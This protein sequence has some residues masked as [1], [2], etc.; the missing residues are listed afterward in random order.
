MEKSAD[1]YAVVEDGACTY[2]LR[3]AHCASVSATSTH[4]LVFSAHDL[5]SPARLTNARI[6]L[7]R[8]RMKQC[9]HMPSSMASTRVAG[10]TPPIRVL[11]SELKIRIRA[12]RV[13]MPEMD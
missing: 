6:E 13:P 5:D 11:W 4:L 8:R 12:G 7:L 10:Y 1:I 9:Q 3:P 2:S